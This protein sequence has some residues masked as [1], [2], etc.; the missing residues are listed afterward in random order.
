MKRLTAFFVLAVM[1]ISQFAILAYADEPAVVFISD[2]G[3]DTN[4]GASANQAV[5]TLAVAYRK[6]AK[7]G[8]LVVCG[9]LTVGGSDTVF[10]A[11][12]GEVLITSLYN[13]TDYSHK[14]ACLNISGRLYLSSDTEI[15]DIIIYAAPASMFFCCGNNAVFGKGISVSL[16]SNG[17]YPYIFGGTYGGKSGATSANNSFYDYT[18]QVDS[19]TWQTVRGGNYRSGSEQPMGFV[20]NVRVIINGGSFES[21]ASGS[22]LAVVS[23]TSF[24]AIFT[25]HS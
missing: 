20:G 17:S 22:D 16:N 14:G 12:S 6:L 21:V 13:G 7:G 24:C 23:A 9:P 25:A 1:L 18:V 10:P 2:T 5:K 8:T 3:K 4:T 19:G 11:T 15:R